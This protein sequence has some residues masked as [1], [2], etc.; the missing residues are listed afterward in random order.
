ML[1]KSVRTMSRFTG[2][3]DYIVMVGVG[4]DHHVHAFQYGHGIS[5][6]VYRPKLGNRPHSPLYQSRD[7]E[8][9]VNLL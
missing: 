5:V 9:F 3:R 2:K 1:K 4:T 7:C 6:L 8:K